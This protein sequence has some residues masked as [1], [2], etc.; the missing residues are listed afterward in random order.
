MKTFQVLLFK[1]VLFLCL[2][3]HSTIFAQCLSVPESLYAIQDTQILDRQPSLY[4]VRADCQNLELTYF[5]GTSLEEKVVYPAGVP[6]FRVNTYNTQIYSV[7][8]PGEKQFSLKTV[9]R[10]QAAGGYDVLH[11]GETLQS[12]R[13]IEGSFDL[14]MQSH[15]QMQDTTI[16]YPNRPFWVDEVIQQVW[17][18]IN[19]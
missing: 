16:E 11:N 3:F 10:M 2:A 13:L 4:K 7:Y 9:S 18:K 12:F 5:V 14:L 1:A 17:L 6:V 8:L 19:Y 15:I